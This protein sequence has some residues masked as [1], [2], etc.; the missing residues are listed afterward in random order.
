MDKI[1][2]R[3][4]ADHI[5]VGDDRAYCG[6]K[7]HDQNQQHPQRHDKDGNAPAVAG[8]ALHPKHQGPGGK[9]Q[10][11]SPKDRRQE[12]PHD[13]YACDNQ[14]ADEQ[15]RERYPPEIAMPDGQGR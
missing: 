10:R 4:V 14:A 7:G 11:R 3:H 9:D 1:V 12:R 2:A 15:H 6:P 5:Y 13:P 8:V